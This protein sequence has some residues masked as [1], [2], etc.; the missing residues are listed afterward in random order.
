MNIF[1]LKERCIRSLLFIS[2][3]SATLIVI[4]IIFFLFLEG[5]EVF[6]EIGF[7]EFLLGKEWVPISISPRFG[8]IPLV[9]GTILV[10]IGALLFSVPLGIACAIFTAK[11][12][13][14]KIKS[15][16]KPAIEL[17]AGIPSVVYGFFGMMVLSDWLRIRF[18]Q[19]SGS[20]WLAGSIILG[21]MA[22]PTIV[23]ISEDAISSVP[24]AYEEGSLAMGATKWQTIKN[25]V[26]PS[27]LSGITTA[28]ILGMGRAI[29]ETMA[30]LMVTGN[31]AVI[32]SP[33]WNIFSPVRTMT[34]TL[35]R[36]I[37]EVPRGGVHYHALFGI[38]IILFFIVLIVNMSANTIMT[39]LK[40]KHTSTSKKSIFTL[41]ESTIRKLKFG[42]YGLISIT[43]L[44]L[45]L[46]SLGIVKTVVFIGFCGLIYFISKKISTKN[47]QRAAFTLIILSAI[48]AVL[49]LGLILYFIV[50][51]GVGALSWEF[52]TEAPRNNGRDGGIY[53][54][55]MGTIYLVVGALLFALPLGIG[56]GIYLSEYVKEGKLT[57]IIRTGVDNLNGTPSIVFGLFGF[58]FFVLYLNF[59]VS[60]LAGQL[61]LAFMVLPT[62]IRTTE[63]ALKAV[64]QAARE[65]SLA[66]GATKWQTTRR[67]VL[68]SAMPGVLTGTILAVGRAAGETAP[69]M[70]TAVV[71][72]Q[73]FA[74]PSAFKPVMA[75]PYH[76]YM[77]A[78]SI[79][80]AENNAYG[81]A[82]VLLILVLG[83]NLIAIVIRDRYKRKA[84]W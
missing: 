42:F 55:I 5:H 9:T 47:S 59:G 27:S 25:V 20:S 31:A 12:A 33:L 60:L 41:S 1:E 17:L 45:S 39:R 81:T 2:S 65:G 74:S 4:F 40:E 71:F 16:M 29:G 56:A 57:K 8:I 21:I 67:V 6:S 73:R 69:I 44:Y 15:I 3:V 75:L 7:G 83:I 63:E 34:A 46:S 66:L 80:G 11:I 84:R 64:P 37:G 36:E 52:L 62:I 70:F 78:T 23:S 82:L 22:L 26:I 50:Y 35:G 30:V 58:A 24:R 10:T 18:D 28:V 48:T 72:T 79:H 76:L 13:P 14:S 32:P 38:A 51:R 54:A 68:P 53:P 77:L 49:I 43:L 19:P 61:T